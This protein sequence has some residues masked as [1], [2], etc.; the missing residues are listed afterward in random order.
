MCS[1]DLPGALEAV[2]Y[3]LMGGGRS[4]GMGA[5]LEIGPEGARYRLHR[6]ERLPPAPSKGPGASAGDPDGGPQG[7]AG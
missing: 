6:L 7:D 1:S 5:V 3:D 4:R 2:P